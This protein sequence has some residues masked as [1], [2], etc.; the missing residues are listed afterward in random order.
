MRS[1]KT[2]VTA[3]AVLAAGF[4]LAAPTAQAATATAAS[5]PHAG[6]ACASAVA[7]AQ[8]A[9][10]A[11]NAAAEDLK[12]QVAAGGHPGTAEQDNLAELLDE[13]NSTAS[14]AARACQD[15]DRGRDRDRDRDRD[16]HHCRHHHPHGAM[17]TGVGSTSEGA[18]G[19]EIAGGLGILSAAGLGALALRRRRAGSEG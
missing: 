9:E 18:N 15:A 7:A 8:K 17:R 10:H 19:G 6:S 12:E 16:H 11:Y 13:A 4:V 5:A 3:A 2:T 14:T 1:I